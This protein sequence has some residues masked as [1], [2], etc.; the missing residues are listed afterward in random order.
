MDGLTGGNSSVA[1]AY[2]AD[3]TPE[4]QRDERFGKMGVSSNLGYI[5]GPAFAGILSGTVLGYELPV[6]FAIGISLLAVTLIFVSLP[7][8]EPC[9]PGP[10]PHAMNVHKIMGQEHRSCIQP[11][12]RTRMSM[13]D[14]VRLPAIGIFMAVYFLV[15]LSF[16]FFYVAFP[17]QAA[18]EMQ[19]SVKHTGAFF[20]VMSLFMV[21]VQGVVL[22]HLSRTWTDKRLVCVG[23]IVLGCGFLTLMPANDSLAFVAAILI[24]VGNG[25]M[26][27]PMVALLSKAAGNHQG[28]VQGLAGSVSAAASILGLLLGGIFYSHVTDWLFVLSAGLIF[29]VVILSMW[30]PPDKLKADFAH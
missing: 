8:P 2:V 18:T 14:I 25:L 15:M 21:V 20:S 30:F 24:A 4:H 11:E 23:S 7:N 29:S 16:S 19:W 12:A 1:S 17:V 9:A 10:D 26:W 3:I 28:S 6:I 13:A 22:P 27:P 5:I